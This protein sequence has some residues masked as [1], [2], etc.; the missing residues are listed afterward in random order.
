VSSTDLDSSA[1]LAY[2]ERVRTA[3]IDLYT[4]FGGDKYASFKLEP[5]P[6][7][8]YRPLPKKETDK[9]R[10][11]LRYWLTDNCS[12]IRNK[13]KSERKVSTNVH[14]T[15]LTDTRARGGSQSTA[16]QASTCQNQDS[17]PCHT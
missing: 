10:E 5:R 13:R 8:P 17:I 4:R 16:C 15:L 14:M 9:V 12:R 6:R 7:L 1:T 3:M 2:D 11:Y